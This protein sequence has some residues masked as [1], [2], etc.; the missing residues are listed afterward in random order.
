VSAVL[1]FLC[2]PLALMLRRPDFRA[3]A[4]AE[5]HVSAE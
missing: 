1:L 5:K 3:V 4:V 2:L